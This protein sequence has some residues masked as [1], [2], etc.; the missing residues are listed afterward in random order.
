[1]QT[2]QIVPDF[3]HT[4]SQTVFIPNLL[5]FQLIHNLDKKGS[6]D[7]WGKFISINLVINMS[8]KQM[9]P[10][11]VINDITGRVFLLCIFRRSEY[12]SIINN[13]LGLVS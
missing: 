6:S 8:C 7:L 4:I 5:I 11:L 9:Q 1:M 12:I 3:I 10:V 2:A 13:K